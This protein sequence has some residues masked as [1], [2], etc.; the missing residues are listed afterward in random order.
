MNGDRN[1][2]SNVSDFVFEKFLH[3]FLFETWSILTILRG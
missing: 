3:E 1:C 2:V